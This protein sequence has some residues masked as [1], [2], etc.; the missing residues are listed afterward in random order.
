MQELL[1]SKIL[2][3]D[4]DIVALWKPYG[5]HMFT[6]DPDKVHE[7]EKKHAKKMKNLSLETYLPWLASRCLHAA[8]GFSHVPN[9]WTMYLIRYYF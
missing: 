5:L 8:P 6:T 9:F 3:N 1:F 2:Y 4:H 7:K